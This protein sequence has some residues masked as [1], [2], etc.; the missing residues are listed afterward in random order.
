MVSILVFVLLVLVL[1]L[2][3]FHA[4]LSQVIPQAPTLALLA[5]VLVLEITVLLAHHMLQD[6]HS[7][8]VSSQLS[9]AHPLDMLSFKF[10]QMFQLVVWLA[11]HML[12]L[13]QAVLLLLI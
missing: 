5:M 11:Q 13:V 9:L 8:M 1:V 6:A 4:H 12:Q 2:V 10:Q 7:Q 3:L